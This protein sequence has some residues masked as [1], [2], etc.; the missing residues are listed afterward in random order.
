MLI[1]AIISWCSLTFEVWLRPLVLRP[2]FILAVSRGVR[3][4][5]FNILL[6]P[7]PISCC[8]RKCKE[9]QESDS[10]IV[11][12]KKMCNIMWNPTIYIIYINMCI[13]MSICVYFMCLYIS[14]TL[15]LTYFCVPAICTFQNVFILHRHWILA[16]QPC[17]VV[18]A[19]VMVSLLQAGSSESASS[20]S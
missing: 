11:V 16:H 6:P 20:V 5:I 4:K 19:E 12:M 13:Y 2:L 3:Q 8:Q 1:G 17:Q 10:I 7:S 9:E 18:T 15:G 14:Q